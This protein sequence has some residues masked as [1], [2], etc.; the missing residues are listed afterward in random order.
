MSWIS[1]I[2]EVLRLIDAP[3]HYY[4]HGWIGDVN[5]SEKECNQKG[6]TWVEFEDGR[7]PCCQMPNEPPCGSA[8][9]GGA[10]IP[11][12]P[13]DDVCAAFRRMNGDEWKKQ[14][15][16]QF[17]EMLKALTPEEQK[18]AVKY[19]DLTNP[20]AIHRLA[21]AMFDLG[22]MKGFPLDT[23]A[24]AGQAQNNGRDNLPADLRQLLDSMSKSPAGPQM[25][26]MLGMLTMG[27]VSLFGSIRSNAHAKQILSKCCEAGNPACSLLKTLSEAEDNG[28]SFEDAIKSKLAGK[29][30][31]SNGALGGAGVLLIGGA[32]ALLLLGGKK[33]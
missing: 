18:V 26:M 11:L 6:G 19:F 15:V 7:P 29:K 21:V 28:I 5:D 2:D 13:P 10:D 30:P 32:L 25:A 1:E 20:K 33:K 22:G 14:V 4:S 12:M 31:S 24:L 16:P 8:G 9:A 23:G 27:G 17:K 3:T